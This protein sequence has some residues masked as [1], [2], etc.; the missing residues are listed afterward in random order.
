MSSL[1]FSP[2]GIAASLARHIPTDAAPDLPRAAV[3]CVLS[4]AGKAPRVLLMKRAVR[5]GDL[6]SGHMALPGG[7]E[8]PCDESLL[9]TAIRE[10][11][12]EVGLDLAATARVLGRLDAVRAVARSVPLS[13]TITPFV[14]TV[15]GEPALSLGAEA[16]L[17]LWVPLLQMASGELDST[18]RYEAPEGPITLPCW[19]FH[20]Q[21]VWGLTYRMLSS[22]LAVIAV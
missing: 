20:G 10:T 18:L 16:E 1:L 9:A 11:Y 15:D 2:A 3:A 6:W 13:L 17:A 19:R 21:V 4:F 7:R 14:L 12:E 22:L 8:D 5:A